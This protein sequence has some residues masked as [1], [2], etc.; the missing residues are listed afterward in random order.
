M[1][2]TITSLICNNF[3][4]IRHKNAIFT[5]DLVT[6]QDLQNVELYDTE[7]NGGVGIRTSKGN[8]A[9]YNFG[10]DEKVINIFETKQYN[11]THFL[12]HTEDSTIGRLYLFDRNHQTR[13]LLINNLTK[14]GK[15]CG[16]DVTQ[17]WSDLFVFTTGLQMYSVEFTTS[18]KVKAMNDLVDEDNNKVMG[19]GIA[20]FD[21]RLWVFKENKLWYSQQ[22]DIY[23]FSSVDP[24]I[25]TSAGYIEFSK[26]ITAIHPYLESLAI[27]HSDSSCM[28]GVS[29]DEKFSISDESVGGCASINSL[30]FHD[31]ELYFYDDTKKSIFSFKQV[32]TGEKALGENVA[33]E[34]QTELISKIDS[35]NLDKIKTLSV[36]LADRNEI[37]WLIPTTD[38]NYSTIYIYD[39]L[40]HA[41]LRRKCQKINCFNI[42]NNALYSANNKIY[43][44]YSTRSF[45]GEFIKAYYKT[46]P[47]NLGANNTL[48]VLYFPPRVTLDLP[49][50][51]QF[52]VKYTKNFDEFKTPKIKLIKA[53]YKNFLIWDVGNWDINYW[54]TRMVNAIG[55]F[56]NATFKTLEMEIYTDNINQNFSIR[57]MEFSKIK[58]KQ[59]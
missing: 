59:V 15:S 28:L 48:K 12:V 56:P 23:N 30:V 52:Y 13:T 24:T 14:T 27:F 17:G 42:V 21:N 33:N 9:I 58:V 18:N 3:S 41:W 11:K 34:I 5:S 55:K 43:E 37:W 22:A 53:K 2:T 40:H 45:D 44:E 51:N 35:S 26:N 6:A 36:V 29:S 50:I 54:I 47:L 7:L 38:D 31:T 25:I 10:N 4:G 57:N 1:T 39:Y 16:L 19:L 46:S 32:I 8:K 49:S 20:V